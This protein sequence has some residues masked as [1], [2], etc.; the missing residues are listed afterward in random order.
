VVKVRL[1]NKPAFEVTGIKT[2]I[3]KVEDFYNFWSKCHEDDTVSTLKSLGNHNITGSLI[4]G[5]SRVENDPNNREFFFYIATEYAKNDN[6][7]FETFTIPASQWAIFECKGDVSNALF[8]A[9]MY[10]FKEWLPSSGYIH[11]KAPELEVYPI[12][13]SQAVEFWLPIIK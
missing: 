2:W 7:N 1:E 13:D 8:E 6:K 3:S 11:A 12:R 9:E 5:V 10:A 4:F